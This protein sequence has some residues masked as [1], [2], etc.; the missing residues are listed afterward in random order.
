MKTR[1]PLARLLRAAAGAP[2]SAADTGSF[3]L[4]A[5]VMAAWRGA[6]R[7][8][9]GETYVVWLRR[10]TICACLL[11]L[12]SLVWN[13]GGLAGPG[14]AGDELAVADAAMRVGVEP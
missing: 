6:R 9:T 7:G 10:A 2:R 12:M 4:E 13:Y 3:A 14:P 1:E 8:G 5:R 11:A